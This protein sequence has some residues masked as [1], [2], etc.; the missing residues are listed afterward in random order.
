MLPNIC[1]LHMDPPIL[2]LIFI[3]L[4]KRQSKP[5]IYVKHSIRILLCYRCDNLFHLAFEIRFVSKSLH[6]LLEWELFFFL[7]HYYNYMD[8]I[9]TW[10]HWRISKNQ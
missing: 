5:N 1:I 9:N 10:L 4:S 2:F 6:E 3:G 7:A 8:Q